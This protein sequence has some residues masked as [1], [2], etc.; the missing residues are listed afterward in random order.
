MTVTLP[1]GGVKV[2]EGARL[3]ALVAVVVRVGRGV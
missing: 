1:G 3:G 2:S